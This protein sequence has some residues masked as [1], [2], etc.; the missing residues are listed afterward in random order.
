MADITRTHPTATTQNTIM[1]PAGGV[2]FIE[3]DYLA[4]VNGKTGPASTIAAVTRML[5]VFG[6]V[7][8]A[9]PLND[10]NTRQMF[11]LEGMTT[12]TAVAEFG[13]LTV[14][15]AA[16]QALGTVDSINL[17]SATAIFGGP[18]SALQDVVGDSDVFPV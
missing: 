14:I 2:N 3:I 1:S 9:G 15:Q 10:S 7:V 11:G 5:G 18:S 4:A 6:T 13:T 17:G 16:L 12:D 8:Y